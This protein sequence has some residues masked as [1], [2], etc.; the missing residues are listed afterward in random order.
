LKK[1]RVFAKKRRRNRPTAV[2]GPGGGCAPLQTGKEENIRKVVHFLTNSP[3]QTARER[4]NLMQHRTIRMVQFARRLAERGAPA[5]P[6]KC[7]LIHKVSTGF[8]P[9]GAARTD[10]NEPV[11]QHAEWCGACLK[12]F[13]HN[14]RRMPCAAR[15]KA[16]RLRRRARFGRVRRGQTPLEWP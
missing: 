15:P 4:L 1:A 3:L 12:V 9:G 14:S 8:S 13:L 7:T 6:G 16:K 11:F 10:R 5:V 2:A